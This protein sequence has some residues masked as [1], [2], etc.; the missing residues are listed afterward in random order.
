MSA[1]SVGAK[2]VPGQ[3]RF[4]HLVPQ[5]VPEAALD[6]AVGQVGVQDVRQRKREDHRRQQV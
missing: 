1:T 6:A 5:Q 2:D 3:H 4:V